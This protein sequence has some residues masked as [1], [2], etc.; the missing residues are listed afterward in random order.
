MRKRSAAARL[1]R[2]ML[3][4]PV[5]AVSQQLL[6]NTGVQIPL[7]Q[8]QA[9]AEQTTQVNN[10]N[11]SSRADTD[12]DGMFETATGWSRIGNVFVDTTV[13]P[14]T[15]TAATSPFSAQAR[16]VGAQPAQGEPYIYT[17]TIDRS[18]LTPNANYIVSAYLWNMGRVSGG[19]NRDLVS[20]KVQD[21]DFTLSNVSASLEAA[22]TDTQSAAD[23]RLV[24]TMVNES[25]MR[26]W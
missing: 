6:A 25:Q 5:A 24:Y 1:G 15:N 8:Y 18:T 7:S 12:N 17:Q 2:A 14:P 26:S 23:G 21:P 11:F 9:G 10:G 19:L 20:V 22:G 4:L 16:V 3:V 13:N